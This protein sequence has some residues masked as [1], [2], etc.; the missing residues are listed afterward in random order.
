MMADTGRVGSALS[1]HAAI[2]AS[3]RRRAVPADALLHPVALAAIGL[4]LLNDHVLKDAAP[5]LVTGKLS[6]VAGLAFFPLVL[7]GAWE[8]ARS[9]VGRWRGPSARA[10]AVS[11][12]VTAIA[13]GLV[14]TTGLVAGAFATTLGAAQWAAGLALAVG[15]GSGE[16]VPAL[17]VRD[18][19]DLVALPAVLI[20][21]WIGWSRLPRSEARR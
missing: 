14:K 4:L 3:E 20:A 7:L 2:D 12:A 9:A 16:I 13:F 17:V 19:T 10:L 8:V 21:A 1:L 18:P 11:V 15:R 5:G 6:D